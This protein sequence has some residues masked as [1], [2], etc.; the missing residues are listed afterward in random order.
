[1]L[2]VC[3]RKSTKFFPSNERINPVLI[4]TLLSNSTNMF[5]FSAAGSSLKL[6][7]REVSQ[8]WCAQ[9]SYANERRWAMGHFSGAAC[10]TVTM[11]RA[12]S[13]GFQE[14]GRQ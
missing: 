14:A 8:E 11:T 2:S 12:K 3:E 5:F 4:Q 1:M 7:A 6:F 9:I 13:V 10:L